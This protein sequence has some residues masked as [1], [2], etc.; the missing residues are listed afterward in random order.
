MRA[1]R[2]SKEQSAINAPVSL[3]HLR[4]NIRGFHAA[5]LTSLPSWIPIEPDKQSGNRSNRATQP[6]RPETRWKDLA[7]LQRGKGQDKLLGSLRIVGRL[8]CL[9]SCFATLV[10]A[11]S[12]WASHPELLE[13]DLTDAELIEEIS[14]FRSGAGHDFSYDPSFEAFGSTD[15]SEPDSSMK[16]YLAPFDRFSGD[17]STIPVYAPFSGEITRVTNETN[18]TRVNKRVEIESSVNSTYLLVLF[19]LDLDEKYPQIYNDWPAHLWPEHLPD[20]PS[21]TTRTVSAGDLLGYADMRGSNDFDVA[22]LWTDTDGDRYW[23]SYFDLMPDSIF[24][25]YQ[26]RGATRANLTISKASRIAVPVTWFGGRND[27][28]WVTLSSTAT[29][30]IPLWVVFAG[31]LGVSLQAFVLSRQKQK[32]LRN[33]RPMAD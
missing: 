32:T 30:P 19:H 7:Q 6:I 2:L 13:S 21:Y 3:P 29:V 10:A 24:S 4:L 31:S 5:G 14:K 9:L 25:A 28:D 22:V 18:G 17:Q 26:V 27:D 20:D 11:I 33:S 8:R 1:K 12:T 15:S 23:I 16:H